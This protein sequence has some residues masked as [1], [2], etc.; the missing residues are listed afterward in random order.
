MPIY[1]VW[2]SV[3]TNFYLFNSSIYFNLCSFALF[4]SFQLR[5]IS[6]FADST[7]VS[8]FSFGVSPPIQFR[9]IST[10]LPGMFLPLQLGIFLSL[11]LG[12]LQSRQFRCISAFSTS[13]YFY[14]FSTF[15]HFH[16]SNL[17]GLL[18]LKLLSPYLKMF[19][20]AYWNKITF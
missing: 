2:G 4:L 5:L 7:Y 19:E 13:T 20:K 16:L 15:A 18:Y 17:S 1:W 14:L 12:I 10:C 8:L 9:C 6:A 3:S 11:H